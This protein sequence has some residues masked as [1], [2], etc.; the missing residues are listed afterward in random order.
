M[1]LGIPGQVKEFSELHEHQA[2][3]EVS[4]VT[5]EVNIGLLEDEQLKLGDWVLIHVGFAM[6]K[7]DEEEA[8]QALDLLKAMGEAYEDEL[9]ALR[10]SE[11][12][13]ESGAT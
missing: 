4:G 3:V 8:T 7:I 9:E 6:A 12:S 2:R 1:C 5:R 13:S 11:Y 10:S